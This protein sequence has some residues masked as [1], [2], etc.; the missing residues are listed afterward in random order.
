IPKSSANLT[1]PVLLLTAAKD[2]IG[3]PARAELSTRPYAPDLIVKSIDSGHFTM[4]EKADEI[5]EAMREFFEA[6]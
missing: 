5:N 4:L 1:K 2:P 6:M 3:T